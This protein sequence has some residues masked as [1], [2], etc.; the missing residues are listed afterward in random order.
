MFYFGNLFADFKN[1]YLLCNRKL[2]AT[3]F[4]DSIKNNL[5]TNKK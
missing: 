1:S 2:K 3:G 4:Q 5:E